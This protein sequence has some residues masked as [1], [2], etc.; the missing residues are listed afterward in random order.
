MLKM[1]IKLNEEKIKNENEYDLE[2]LYSFIDE[3]FKK[4]GLKVIETGV[5]EGDFDSEEDTFQFMMIMSSY[6][7][8]EW[9]KKYVLEWVLYEGTEEPEDLLKS[10]KIV[11]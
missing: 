11:G 9:F 5:Y 6:K 3:N 1:V 7:K 4:R 10:F 8:A 2:Y